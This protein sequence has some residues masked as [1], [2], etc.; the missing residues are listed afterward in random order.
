MLLEL[1]S[2]FK[3]HFF[4]PPIFIK[5]PSLPVSVK[6]KHHQPNNLCVCVSVFVYFVSDLSIINNNITSLYRLSL[7]LCVCLCLCAHYPALSIVLHP[8]LIKD[9]HPHTH[10]QRL[11]SLPVYSDWWT[12]D[13][14][15]TWGC[16][17]SDNKLYL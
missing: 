15:W 2:C 11:L 6:P 12:A 9:A 1:R 3:G 10:R 5:C 7:D 17:K 4:N 16:F 14:A 13:F 8:A